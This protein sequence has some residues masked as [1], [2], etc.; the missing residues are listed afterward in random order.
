MGVS[1]PKKTTIF[2]G[3]S[4]A[5]CAGPLSLVISMFEMLKRS[6]ISLNLVL[7]VRS[8]QRGFCTVLVM[9]CASSLAVFVPMMIM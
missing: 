3:V 8:M 1:G 9:V 7:P 5:K 2:M 4:D 6:M